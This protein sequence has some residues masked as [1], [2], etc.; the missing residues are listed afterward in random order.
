MQAV[1]R[2]T[3]SLSEL[4]DLLRHEEHRHR[5]HESEHTT[6]PRSTPEL[7]SSD[8]GCVLRFSSNQLDMA[9]SFVAAETQNAKD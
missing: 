6:W 5:D 3:P 8:A 9:A 2:Q 4:W 1:R 7:A